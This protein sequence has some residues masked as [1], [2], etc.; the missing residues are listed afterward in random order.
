[1]HDLQSLC[2]CGHL[3]VLSLGSA[4]TLAVCTDEGISLVAATMSSLH[5]ADQMSTPDLHLARNSWLGQGGNRL[6]RR[7]STGP[8]AF[9]LGVG[10]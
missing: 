5:T 7:I 3:I 9:W 6:A 10:P 1:M 2:E 4:H 8:R